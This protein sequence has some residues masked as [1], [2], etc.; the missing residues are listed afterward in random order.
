M[1][2]I[3]L[4]FKV[5][6]N[7]LTTLYS[8]D[9]CIL[10]CAQIETTKLCNCNTYDIDYRVPGFDLCLQDGQQTCAYS[11]WTSNFTKNTFILDHCISKCP[12]ECSQRIMTKNVYYYQYPTLAYAQTTSTDATLLQKYPNQTD[13]TVYTNLYRNMAKLSVFYETLAYVK[14][15]EKAEMTFDNLLGTLGGHLHLFLGM[16]MLSFFELIELII[17]SIS[18]HYE[19]KK[20]RSQINSKIIEIH[21]IETLNVV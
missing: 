15:E 11:F 4:T 13:F 7:L 14:I 6:S 19:R 10:F 12:L 1:V 3:L 5:V 9:S 16:S 21:K 8:R 20:K 17:I 2:R 18:I